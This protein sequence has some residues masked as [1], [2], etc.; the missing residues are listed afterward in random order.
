MKQALLAALTVVGGALAASP[1]A[2]SDQAFEFWLNPSIGTDLD[3]DTAFELETAQRFRPQ[4]D[5]RVDTYF[6]R[7][8]LKQDLA[9]NV[10]LA[11]AIEYRVNDGGANE[12]R[13]MQQLSTSHGILK[14]RL[15]LE[16]RFVDGADRM[17]LRL[18]PRLG[19]GFDLSRDGRWSAGADAE[20]FWVLRGN[21]AGSDTGLTGLRTTIGVD[22]ALTENLS[23][24]L[25]YLRQQDFEDN[26]PDEIAH[27]PLIG[28]EYS[29]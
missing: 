26:G 9:D 23:V 17:G 14:T 15:R 22:Y 11:G 5:G 6:A 2:A 25:S 24:G 16:Q 29:F 13:T 1:A 28:I 12:V 20:L 4:S 18:R 8:W 7:A 19:V 27:A 3:K 10:T 21:N